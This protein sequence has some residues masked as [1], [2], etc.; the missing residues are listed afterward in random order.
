MPE[1][2]RGLRAQHAGAVD[3]I[4]ESAGVD[5]QR[6]QFVERPLERVQMFAKRLECRRREIARHASQRDR[7]PQQSR[8]EQPGPGA[9][10]SPSRR[11][12]ARLAGTVNATS[13]AMRADVGDV[14]V[15][16][17]QLQQ[18]HAERAR[19]GGHL[20]AARGVRS[21][22]RRPARDRPRCRRRSIRP[23]TGRAATAA[24]RSASRFPCARRR[25][26]AGDRGRARRRRQ[27][28]SGP[29]R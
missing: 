16:A 4:G 17:L 25:A 22:A 7:A 8:A 15:D 6:D 1:I 2:P 20:D 23:G 10:T 12:C 9:R 26:G 29:A 21:R 19:A 24:A 11:T 18:H 28:G 5:Q 27:I 3:T 13:V 14:V